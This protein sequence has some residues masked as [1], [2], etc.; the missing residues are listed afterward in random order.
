VVGL[1]ILMLALGARLYGLG[2]YLTADDQ[3]WVRRTIGFGRAVERGRFRDTFQSGH[4][5]VPVLWLAYQAI[6]SQRIAALNAADVNDTQFEK[7]PAYLGA[8][9][10]VRLVLAFHTAALAVAITWLCWRLFGA[11]TAILAGLLLACEPFLVAHGQLFETDAMLAALMML[12]V[13]SGLVYCEGRGG[14]AFWLGSGLLAGLAFSTKAPA[15]LLFGF[16]PLV[17]VTYCALGLGRWRQA[18]SRLTWTDR[19]PRLRLDRA[20]LKPLYRD[21][22]LWGLAAG[23]LYIVLWP[24][25]W[26]DPLRTLLRLERSV[27][28]VGES[29]RRW[30]NFFLGTIYDDEDVALVLRPLFYPLV[31]ALRLSPITFV[32]LVLLAATFAR[33]LVAFR[34]RP[35]RVS[36][37]ALAIGLYVLLYTA[38]MTISPKKLDRYLMPAYPALVILGALGLRAMLRWVQAPR[39]T[40]A[41]IAG[42]GLAQAVLIAEVQPYSLSFYNPLLGGTAMARRTTVVGWGEG[43]D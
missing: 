31:T 11:R 22:A 7:S 33:R 23:L 40:W 26:V 41:M 4:P 21:L 27:R 37:P 12:S 8:V 38:M 30:G 10:D 25:M 16:I 18:G 14:W 3:D 35:V 24:A 28:S 6:G 29:P 1:A 20:T 36:G 17:A 43:L 19:R 32:G 9:V 42:L 2:Q 39:L 15:I 34:A 13:L 5:G